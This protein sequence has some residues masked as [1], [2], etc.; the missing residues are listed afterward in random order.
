MATIPVASN[1]DL[2]NNQ[3]LNVRL[4]MLSSAPSDL[5]AKIYYDTTLHT[6]LLLQH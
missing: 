6:Q 2:N 5:E 4:Q 3:I 1:Q